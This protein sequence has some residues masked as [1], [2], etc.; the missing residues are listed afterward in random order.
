M[1]R[2]GPDPSSEQALVTMAMH[3]QSFFNA[4]GDS[5]AFTGAIGFPSDSTNTTECGGT[6]LSTTGPDGSYVSELVWNEGTPNANGGD[7]GSSGGVSTYYSI[8]P[9]QQGVATVANQGSSVNRNVPDV[10]MTANNI[11]VTYDD[12][13]AGSFGG[14]S[15]AAP[16]WAGFI[17]LVNQQAAIN[18]ASPVGFLNPALYA[19]GKGPNY[20]YCFHDITVGNNEWYPG[21][22]TKFSAVPGYD[23]CTGWG[24][25][26]GANLMQALL[27]LGSGKPYIIS[28]GSV[29]S[30]GNANGVIDYDDCVLLSLPVVNIGQGTATVVNATLT[31]STP[32]VTITQSNST[33]ANLP[34]GAVTTNNTPFQISTS[35]SFVCGTPIPLSLVLSYTAGSVTN[36]ITMPTCQCPTIQ[37]NGSLSGA[38]P[39][40]S[41]ALWPSGTN[42]T[43]SLPKSCPARMERVRSPITLTHTRTQA[44]R[45]SACR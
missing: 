2:G 3:G 30:G 1:E 37:T 16:L 45:Q 31:T 41:G 12:G 39:T 18:S 23:L 25:P 15:C 22:T 7:W 10:A 26:N 38:S 43:C 42:S 27:S 6:D 33:Y 4:V 34:S 35:P 20:A 13:S 24:S 9:W 44:V 8:P 14:T 17:A 21:S 40:Q 11:Y 32:G 19:I 5:D 28:T 36:T 29:V